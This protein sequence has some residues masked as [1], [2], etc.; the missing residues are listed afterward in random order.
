[1]ERVRVIAQQAEAGSYATRT[2]TTAEQV[3]AESEAL[4][5]QSAYIDATARFTDAASLYKSASEDA[6]AAVRMV[7]RRAA[8]TAGARA[9]ERRR[10]AE[11]AG[12]PREADTLWTIAGEAAA[13]GRAAADRGDFLEASVAFERAARVFGEAETAARKATVRRSAD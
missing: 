9:A 2:W 8:E 11:E 10:L 3:R 13:L 12:A 6:R 4:L 1:T 5:S 7:Q